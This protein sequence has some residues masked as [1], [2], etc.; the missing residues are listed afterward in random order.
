MAS[1]SASKGLKCIF[2]CRRVLNLFN[3]R[4]SLEWNQPNAA[5]LYWRDYLI[6]TMSLYV[7][8]LTQMILA[9]SHLNNKF[10]DKDIRFLFQPVMLA[11]GNMSHFCLCFNFRNSP[12]AG[13]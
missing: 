6:N 7:N 1:T 9:G 10:T 13:G 5:K 3:F 8:S 4:F 11:A 2:P 12:S